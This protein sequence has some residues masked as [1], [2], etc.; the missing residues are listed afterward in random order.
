MEHEGRDSTDRLG[1]MLTV[2]AW[3]GVPAVLLIQFAGALSEPTPR[4]GY[5]LIVVVILSPII[6]FA[7][8][9]VTPSAFARI[10]VRPGL[11]VPLGVITPVAAGLGWL[12]GVPALEFFRTPFLE[13]RILGINLSI[14]LFFLLYLAVWC[15]YAAWQTRLV[16][17]DV[18]GDQ[19]LPAEALRE[20]PRWFPRTLLIEF[21]GHATIL[22]A[23]API[24]LIAGGAMVIACFLIIIAALGWNFVTAGFLVVGLDERLGAPAALAA[25][26][27]T[28]VK[29]VR[30]W[31]L[32]V[33]A[34]MLLLGLVTLVVVSYTS[35]GSEDGTNRVSQVSK[36]D[37][38]VNGSWTGGYPDSTKWLDKTMESVEADVPDV[39]ATVLALLLGLFAILVKLHIAEAIMEEEWE[40]PRRTG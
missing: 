18:L 38:G 26:F 31:W 6:L 21:I 4:Q 7:A 36:T 25:G 5:A 8:R 10:L 39:A 3:L 22:L 16:I 23:M 29:Y 24:I 2:I 14:S 27:R 9:I 30:R 40:S 34:Q 35:S 32:P 1:T 19:A 33:L 20:A 17:A 13:T 15:F 28:S 37:W 11:L 12:W